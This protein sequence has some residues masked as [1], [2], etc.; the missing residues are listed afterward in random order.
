M[1]LWF[2]LNIIELFLSKLIFIKF[3]FSLSLS[4]RNIIIMCLANLVIT[5]QYVIFPFDII[6][7]STKKVIQY[8]YILSEMI[9]RPSLLTR[10][11]VQ[12]PTP[13]PHPSPQPPLPPNPTSLQILLLV[14]R[15]S[16]ASQDKV[17]HATIWHRYCS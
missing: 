15:S 3:V 4:L 6:G 9:A 5:A 13:S 8:F 16:S 17:W 11:P 7:T 1:L 10:F 14:K 12:P 2:H